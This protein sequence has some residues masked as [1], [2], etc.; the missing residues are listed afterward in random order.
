MGLRNPN[1]VA[2]DAI[3]RGIGPGD[4]TVNLARV[5]A[6]ITC[7]RVLPELPMNGAPKGD[8]ALSILHHAPFR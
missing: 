6:K 3:A 7:R 1:E 8:K 4:P 5:H 2:D